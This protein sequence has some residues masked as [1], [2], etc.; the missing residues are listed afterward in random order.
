MRTWT[1]ALSLSLLSLAANAHAH[2]KLV[3]PP[4]TGGDSSGKGAPPCGP[5]GASSAPVAVTGGHILKIDVDETVIHPGF[6]RIALAINSRS[7]LPIDNVVKDAMGKVLSPTGSPSGTSAS[8]EYESPAVFPVLADHLWV[9]TAD[10]GPL[11]TELTLP[12]VTCAKCTLQVIEF[13]ANH[14]PNPGGAYFYHHCADLKITADPSLPAFGAGGAGGTGGGS[15]AS[16]A[17]AGGGA[18][19][20][21][22]GSSAGGASAGASAGGSSVSGGSG[23]TGGASSDTGGVAGSATAGGTIDAGGSGSPAPTGGSSPGASG[24]SAVEP[25]SASDD[26]GGCAIADRHASR[27]PLW[28][29]LFALAVLGSR[30]R[31]RSAA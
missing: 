14:G 9:H 12:N 1:L 19:A 28:A 6:Y 2:F 25:P 15:G 30:R 21:A 10:P 11:H 5:D 16:G 27:Q 20:G 31:R 3:N 24:A 29:A 8:A 13:M 23:G 18:H 4:S 17:G 22:T 7:E 26:S